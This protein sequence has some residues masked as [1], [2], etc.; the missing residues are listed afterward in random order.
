MAYVGEMLSLLSAWVSVWGA[1]AAVPGVVQMSLVGVLVLVMV[2]VLVLV[3]LPSVIPYPL[4]LL[5]VT[6]RVNLFW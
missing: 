2:G 4:V 6:L 5:Q 1:A 3:V